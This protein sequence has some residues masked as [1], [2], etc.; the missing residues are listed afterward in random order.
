[1]SK[2]SES[3]PFMQLCVKCIKNSYHYIVKT[4]VCKRKIPTPAPGFI[5][6]KMSL[7]VR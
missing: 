7:F 3:M 2:Y 6:K 4:I 1:M 5:N